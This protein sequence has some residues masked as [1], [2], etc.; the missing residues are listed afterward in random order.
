[1][2]TY[3]SIPNLGESVNSVTLSDWLV[4]DFDYVQKDQVLC[5]V[6][7]DKSTFEI[8]AEAS[9]MIRL[10]AWRSQEVNIGEVICV[11]SNKEDIVKTPLIPLIQEISELIAKM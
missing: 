11:I 5:E 9:G 6:Q 2:I 4:G 8:V 7:S 3:I 1:M 10:I